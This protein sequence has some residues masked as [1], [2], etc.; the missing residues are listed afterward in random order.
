M[1]IILGGVKRI[2]N[3]S[4]KMV[5]IMTL[6]YII[7]CF[8]IILVHI[9]EVPNIFI[10]IFKSA[11]NFKSIKGGLLGSVIIGM[12][13]GI[14]SSEA[15]IGTGAISASIVQT[16]TDKEKISQGYT[17]ILGIYITTFLI[18]TSTALILLTSDISELSFSNFNGI[19]LI[20]ISFTQHVGSWGKYFVFLII[21]LFSF[22]TILSSYYNGESSLKYFIE[23]PKKSL[24]LLKIGTLIS[25]FFGAI[26]SSN[27]IWNFIDLF[28]GILA[29]LNIYSIIKLKN[30]VIKKL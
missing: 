28:V 20:Q 2:A 27:I 10:N 26:S 16:D 22:T 19:E 13:R 8:V 29:I 14:F 23:N 25:I 1:F 6:L 11:F 5:P 30:K 3:F 18:C 7:V 9:K 4:S 21:F 12:Q 17:Q 15:G 24:K